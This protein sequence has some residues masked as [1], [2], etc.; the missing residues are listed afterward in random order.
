MFRRENGSED[1]RWCG[2]SSAHRPGVTECLP[3]TGSPARF[4]ELPGQ[5]ARDSKASLV[6]MGSLY[7]SRLSS[8]LLFQIGWWGCIGGAALGHLWL[9]PTIVAL[10]AGWELGRAHN[11]L[12][13]SCLLAVVTTGGWMLDTKLAHLGV[14]QF[15]TGAVALGYSPAWM[16]ALWTNLALALPGG[17]GFL[18]RRPWL[19]GILGGIGGPAAYLGGA[20]LG[21]LRI[22]DV[23][24]LSAVLGP[25]WAV[26]LP[27]LF[28]IRR[29]CLGLPS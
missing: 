1:V 5:E 6:G 20:G 15:T 25:V 7:G 4:R 14:F 27:L 26:V 9:G 24:T 17:L 11:R 18:E 29:Q 2:L 3:K 23:V 19:A 12:G 10:L 13:L 28:W 8:L 16:A 22:D 21:V